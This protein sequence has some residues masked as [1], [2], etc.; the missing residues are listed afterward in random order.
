[1]AEV[2]WQCFEQTTDLIQ[3]AGTFTPRKHSCAIWIPQNTLCDVRSGLNIFAATSPHFAM[4]GLAAA[5]AGFF[6]ALVK[7]TKILGP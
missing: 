7:Q 3:S 4:L 5:L 2:V 6:V 1:M